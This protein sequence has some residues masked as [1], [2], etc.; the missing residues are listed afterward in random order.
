MDRPK[1]RRLI[2]LGVVLV[3][4]GFVLLVWRPW[5]STTVPTPVVEKTEKPPLAEPIANHAEPPRVEA[6]A[7][8]STPASA[9][10]GTF[11]G[12][13]LDAATRQPVPEFEVQLV[14]VPRG[15]IR[16]NEPRVAQTFESA[17]GRFAWQR[18]PVGTW[19]VMVSAPGYQ[20]FRFDGL[21]IV[22]GKTSR[23]SVMPMRRGHTLKGRVFDQGSGAGIGDAWVA[24][25]DASVPW[26]NA[27]PTRERSEKSKEDGT[28]VLDGVPGGEMI[29]MVG[30]KDHANRELAV[31]VGDDTPPLEIGLAAGAKIAGMVLGPDGTPAQKGHLLL[32]GPGIPFVKPLDETG[33]FSFAHRPAGRYLLNA[34]TPAGNARLEIELAENEI[35]EDIVLKVSEGRSIR[36]VI[37]GLRPEQLER[38]FISVR[39]VAKS[40]S[41]TANP[42]A[43]G[44]Y[45]VRGVP[46][47]RAEVHVTANMSRHTTRSLDVP[48]DKDAVLDI[49]F[50]LGARLSGRVTQ[51]GKPAAGRNIWVRSA[52]GGSDDGYQARTNQDGRYEVEGVPPGEY[53]VSVDQDA[54]RVVA[55]AGDAVV[56]IDIPLVQLGGRVVEEGGTVPIVGA[57]VHLTGSERQTAHVR[58]YRETDDFGQFRLTGVEPGEVVLTVYQP[59]YEMYREKILYSSPITNKMIT[60]R[61]SAGVELRVRAAN[62]EQAA[63]VF[64]NEQTPGSNYGISL[65]IPL[66]AE[67]IG[68]L[69]SALA[70]STLR[71][72]RSGSMP[73]VIEKWD[74]QSLELKFQSRQ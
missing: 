15:H 19:N 56:N 57:G 7:P 67:G 53:R 26:P 16:G 31:V 50:P 46:P 20:Q 68:F 72:Q 59:G 2:L 1:H 73:I 22:A 28:F 3:A 55:V 44:D 25:R 33:S 45:I 40:A 5:I 63:P 74:G 43:Q 13:V 60:L 10:G 52:G 14:G 4:V 62:G 49:V 9:E 61:K 65:W 48:A 24:F 38:T 66:N 47:G 37:R 58:N 64:V 8:A 34:T 32:A 23:E 71:I 54:N 29:V 42:D 35:R 12:R 11:R 21:S 18:A 17:D 70:G 36:G 30:A 41:F 69:P 39:S 51:D 6:A 27:D